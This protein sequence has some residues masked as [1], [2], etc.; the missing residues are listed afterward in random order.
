MLELLQ[1]IKDIPFQK[2]RDA[3]HCCLSL[4]WSNSEE[5]GTSLVRDQG[6]EVISHIAQCQ[7]SCA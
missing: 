5:L 4:V 2:N 1:V 3:F 6:K 7:S